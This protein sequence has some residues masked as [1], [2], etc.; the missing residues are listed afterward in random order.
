MSFKGFTLASPSPGSGGSFPLTVEKALAAAYSAEEGALL[1]VDATDKFAECAA[2]PAA[3]AAVAIGPGGADTRGYNILGTKEFPPGYM[4]G[5]S[6][7]NGVRFLAP[8][9]GALPAN[10]GG[11]FGVIRDVDGCWKVDFNELLALVVNYVGQPDFRPD[12]AAASEPLVLVTFIPAI[13]QA[14]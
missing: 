6:V 10:P 11:Q 1:V 3:V 12:L 8:F 4:Q 9:V 14:L 2:D 13:V 5:I 7:N